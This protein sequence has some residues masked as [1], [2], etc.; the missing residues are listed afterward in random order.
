MIIFSCKIVIRA[1]CAHIG[2]VSYSPARG[3]C[4]AK[5]AHSPARTKDGPITKPVLTTSGSQI[6]TIQGRQVSCFG[7][8]TGHHPMRHLMRG[9]A[10]TFHHCRR[11]GSLGTP[12]FL[13]HQLHAF[14]L[15]VTVVVFCAASLL[16]HGLRLVCAAVVQ[17][18]AGMS[19]TIRPRQPIQGS[20]HHHRKQHQHG[21][22]QQHAGHSS[23]NSGI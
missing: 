4:K 7:G 13:A 2:L 22:Y 8:S 3:P 20:G 12:S 11:C 23:H 21:H 9:M 5:S 19:N 16:M 15:V 14:M 17:A 18:T 1:R 10:G 6:P